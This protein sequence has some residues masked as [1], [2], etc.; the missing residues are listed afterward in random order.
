[1]KAVAVLGLLGTSSVIMLFY[2][3]AR[4]SQRFGT[5]IKMPPL[6]RYYYL[7]AAIFCISLVSQFLVI[8][9]P[10]TLLKNTAWLT[11]PWVLLLDY[12]LSQAVGVTIALIVTWRYWRWLITERNE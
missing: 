1:M 11:E 5:V 12:Y 4:L 2:I 6:Y 3:L 10:L 9:S 7:A 8:I